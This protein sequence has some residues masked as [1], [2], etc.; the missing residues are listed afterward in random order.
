V[1]ADDDWSTH[2]SLQ[3]RVVTLT[4]DEDLRDIDR[5]ARQYTGRQYPNR[6][7][8]RVSAQVEIDRWHGWGELRTA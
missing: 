2:V 8:P 4:D 6:Q 5:L 3:G 7:R 1:L